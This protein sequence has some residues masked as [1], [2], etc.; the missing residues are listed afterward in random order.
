MESAGR[1]ADV[2]AYLSWAAAQ[3][4]TVVRVL[5]MAKHLFELPPE[6][7]LAALDAFLS[8][9]SR[10]GLYV[11]VVALAD[12]ASFEMDVR[13]HVRRLGAVAAKHPNAIVEI[14]NEP[15]HSTQREQVHRGEYLEQLRGE[16]P[17][18]VLVALGAADHPNLHTAGDYV[19]FHSSR[20]PAE[21]GWGHVRDIR[22]AGDLLQKA[23]KPLVN[24]EPIGAAEKFEPGR[25][26]DNPERFRAHA[27]A[28]RQLGIYSTFHYEG[29]LQA[30]IPR[31][32]E[33]DCFKAWREGAGF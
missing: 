1:S 17:G 20:S 26:D 27:L 13:S 6:R 22:A 16:I 14:A 10:H 33:L 2:D 30:K 9:A 23:G 28:A 12:T 5:T 31:G 29:G 7:G 18:H 21:N 24:D 3:H 19:T 25:R 8:K 4:L 15:Y 32:R 11:E